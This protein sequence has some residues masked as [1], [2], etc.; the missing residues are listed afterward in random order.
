M[1]RNNSRQTKAF[2]FKSSYRDY[3]VITSELDEKYNYINKNTKGYGN[4]IC[5]G[6]S[7]E[8]MVS[9]EIIDMLM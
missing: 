1:T 5:D 9:K 3:A 4:P 8:V 6:I 7:D 2:V